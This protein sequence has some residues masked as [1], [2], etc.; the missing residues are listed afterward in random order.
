[1]PYVKFTETN[2]ASSGTADFEIYAANQ[3]YVLYDVRAGAQVYNA[4]ASQ[5]IS[6]D[7]NDT[8]DIG[9][10][11]NIVSISEGL[12]I[13]NQLNPVT[14]DW[15]NKAK[16]TNSGFIAQEV[17]KILPDDVSG[18]DYD[19]SLKD[20]PPTEVDN[21]GKSINLGGIVAHLTKAVQE[22]SEQ[23]KVLEKRLEELEGN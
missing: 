8:S 3:T 13:I 16:G 11:E 14:F 17:E 21:A 6:G 18:T 22:L 12:S 23:N 5:V 7:F 19:E 9:F 15:K 1:M 20:L 2:A 4:N 10:K